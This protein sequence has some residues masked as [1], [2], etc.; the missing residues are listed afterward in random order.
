MSESNDA[1]AAPEWLA[2]ET[3][4]NPVSRLLTVLERFAAERGGG[5][6]AAMWAKA[7]GLDD[8]EAPHKVIAQT[9]DLMAEAR[10][11]VELQVEGENNKEL[12]LDPFDH[13]SRVFGTMVRLD[14]SPEPF[15]NEIKSGVMS[16][17]FCAAMVDAADEH[18]RV[19]TDL[20]A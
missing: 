1:N 16:L 15:I 12:Y 18:G 7:F 20:M 3:A 5:Q 11:A 13:L 2:A 4:T 19:D 14:A 10:E 8:G 17:R 9:L 6:V